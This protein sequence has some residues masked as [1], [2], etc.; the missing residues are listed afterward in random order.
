ML[1]SLNELRNF[2]LKA[3]DGEIGRCKDFL[4][5]DAFWTIRYMVADTGKW[6]PKRKVL[7]SPISLGEPGWINR[8][9]P[10]RLTR[11]QIES[12]PPLDADAPIS[13]QFEIKWFAYHGYPYYW[14]GVG[15]WG[16]E[17]LPGPLY[18]KRRD[19]DE[20]A[21]EISEEGSNLRSAEE[22]RGYHIAATDNDIGHVED[23]LLDDQS[24]T[25]HYMIVDT[26]NWL[27][28]RKVLVAPEWIEAIDW[29]V[30]K[31]RVGLTRQQVKE[32]PEYDPEAPISREYEKQ[33]YKFYGRTTYWI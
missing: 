18:A 6:L 9:L 22:V 27:P 30:Q 5:D 16:A 1:R 15:V 28:G 23:F 17:A 12:S 11:E 33:L 24:W 31:V 7:V 19:L 14:G 4:F 2:V 8:R 3:E 10:V 25:I 26:R 20:V 13:R 21:P 32:S 29:E